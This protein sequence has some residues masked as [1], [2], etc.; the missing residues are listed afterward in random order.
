MSEPINIIRHRNQVTEKQLN[1]NRVNA[2]KSTGPC[3]T[4]RTKNNALSHGYYLQYDSFNDI[5]DED[6]NRLYQD[7]IHD[8]KINSSAESNVCKLAAWNLWRYL[9]IAQMEA[10]LYQ[11]GEADIDMIDKLFTL[12][13]RLEKRFLNC[14]HA[15]RQ[16]TT[17]KF[18]LK[19]QE[20]FLEIERAAKL[21]QL[22]QELDKIFS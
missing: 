11:E 17:Y 20:N 1:A 9:K 3:D 19:E 14:L 16:E 8:Y 10:D 15:L 6:L 7:L 5:P 13:S 21:K 12:S 18:K 2:K 22:S 4:S